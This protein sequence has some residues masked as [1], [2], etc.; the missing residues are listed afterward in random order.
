MK[1]KNKKNKNVSLDHSHSS[2][3]LGFTHVKR[4]PKAL[5]VLIRQLEEEISRLQLKVRV[6]QLEEEVS[7]LENQLQQAIKLIN[8]GTIEQE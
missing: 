4:S 6:R 7:Q 1:L 8:V 2:G 3:V 5:K